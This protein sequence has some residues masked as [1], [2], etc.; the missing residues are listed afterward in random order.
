MT[1][2]CGGVFVSSLPFWTLHSGSLCVVELCCE[3]R[4][5]VVGHS[6][7]SFVQS[8][9]MCPNSWQLQHLTFLGFR[10]VA[11]ATPLPPILLTLPGLESRSMNRFLIIA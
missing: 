10:V 6:C 3:L 9:L 1:S 5:H 2:P 4:F 11:I 8:R 7:L